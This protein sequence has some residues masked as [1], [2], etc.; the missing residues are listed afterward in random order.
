MSIGEKNRCIFVALLPVLLVGCAVKREF[1]MGSKSSTQFEN[2]KAECER[3]AAAE[4][5]RADAQAE[6]LENGSNEQMVGAGLGAM[7]VGA[8]EGAGAY[9]KCMRY[10]GYRP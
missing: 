7:L 9:N 8:D 6:A 4:I 2:D 1:S 3:Q 10:K 5:A